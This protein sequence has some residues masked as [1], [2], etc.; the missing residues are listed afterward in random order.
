[1][2]IVLSLCLL[3]SVASSAPAAVVCR[4]VDAQGRTHLADT[5]PERYR[6]RAH[7][8]VS[9]AAHTQQDRK[10]REYLDSEACFARY[11]NPNNRTI[12][13]EAFRHCKEIVDPR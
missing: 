2:K 3:L 8:T 12:R 7:C 13:A 4:W 6:P 10:L 5:V 11:R 9:A 1:M